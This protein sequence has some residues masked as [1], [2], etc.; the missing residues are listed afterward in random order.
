MIVPGGHDETCTWADLAFVGRGLENFGDVDGDAL[1]SGVRIRA[2]D[3]SVR[4]I[5]GEV[6]RADRA[7]RQERQIMMG[8]LAL[9]FERS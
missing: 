6:R 5:E 7:F 1:T 2:V 4:A 9:G 8:G 3:E